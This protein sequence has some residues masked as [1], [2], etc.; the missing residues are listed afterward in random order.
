MEKSKLDKIIADSKILDAKS[1]KFSSIGGTNFNCDCYTCQ[2]DSSR[3]DC[4]CQQSC[5]AGPCFG[6]DAYSTTKDI[7]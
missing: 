1:E 6:G 7:M 4:V 2:C 5:D 3:C